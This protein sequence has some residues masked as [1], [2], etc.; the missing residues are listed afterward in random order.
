M[1]LAPAWMHVRAVNCLNSRRFN[2]EVDKPFGGAA[3]GERGFRGF[4]LTFNTP[5]EKIPVAIAPGL[6]II[7]A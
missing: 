2:Q 1:N 7:L 5:L 3:A 6:K 4:E